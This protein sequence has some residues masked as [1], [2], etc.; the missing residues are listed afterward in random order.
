[1]QEEY[2]KPWLAFRE[3]TKIT[4]FQ[5]KIKSSVSKVVSPSRSGLRQFC[6]RKDPI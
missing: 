5:E 4:E 2:K 3:C 1:M 6:Y